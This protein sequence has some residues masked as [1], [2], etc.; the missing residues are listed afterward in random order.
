[1]CSTDNSS[2][3]DEYKAKGEKCVAKF[4]P[5][6]DGL[7]TIVDMDEKHSTVMIKLPNASNIFPTFHT[8]EVLPFVENNNS[9]FPSQ[10]FEEPPPI[11][12]PEGKKEF[13]INKILDQRCRRQGHQFLVRWR[14][15]EQEHD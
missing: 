3:A 10:K 11:L 7:Y 8:S 12:T 1:M 5:R 15:Y 14:S 4:M 6:Y 13:F 9:L 2:Q